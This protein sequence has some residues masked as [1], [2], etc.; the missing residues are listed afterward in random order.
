M[1]ATPTKQSPAPMPSAEPNRLRAR[2]GQVLQKKRGRAAKN[3][4]RQL[5][6][7]DRAMKNNTAEMVLGT[8]RRVWVRPR[9]L[10][11]FSVKE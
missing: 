7:A 8:P 2:L 6:A 11:K 10:K 9:S 3:S 5:P 4:A 1:K